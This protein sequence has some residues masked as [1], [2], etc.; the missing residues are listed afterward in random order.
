M[1]SRWSDEQRAEAL[2]LYAAHGLTEAVRRSGV[3]RSTLHRW[4]QAAGAESGSRE[5]SHRQTRAARAA[6]TAAH[7]AGRATFAERLAHLADE[8]ADLAGRLLTDLAPDS[9]QLI[10]RRLDRAL[11]GDD[12]VADAAQ[13]WA[14]CLR[15]ERLAA[16][17]GPD[18]VRDAQEATR[19]ARADLE[20]AERLALS[21]RDLLAVL[22]RSV[23]GYL[24]LE[25][26]AA[27]DRGAGAIVVEL[28]IP[29]PEDTATVVDAADLPPR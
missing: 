11:E 9:A 16:D 13:R 10:A 1:P 4:A 17:M 26:A 29:E 15:L 5:H 27:D 28:L 8:R 23:A 14:D 22:D 24:A 12:L 3:P 21:T 18:A 25:G 6:T 20:A 19:S 2:E 7:A